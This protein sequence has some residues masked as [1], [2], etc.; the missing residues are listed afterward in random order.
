M[1]T[2]ASHT[3]SG[4]IVGLVLG[5]WCPIATRI[6]STMAPWRAMTWP[7]FPS[8][9][10]AKPTEPHATRPKPEL[11]KNSQVSPCPPGDVCPGQIRCTCEP[12]ITV[13]PWYPTRC[14]S[15]LHTCV[16]TLKCWQSLAG[17][18]VPDG[19]NCTSEQDITRDLELL[20]SVTETVE[21]A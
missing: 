7:P 11:S 19:S 17:T 2:G 6:R 4:H 5:Q 14:R 21:C 15:S 8:L 12:S 20:R 3:F 1:L 10:R 16:S 13:L 9:W 18:T